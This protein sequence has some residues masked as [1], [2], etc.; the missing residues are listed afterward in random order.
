MFIGLRAL[1]ASVVLFG[2]AAGASAQLTSHRGQNVAP[3]YEGW[4][5]DPDGTRHFVFGYMNRNWEEELDVPV[6]AENFLEPGP[7]DQGQPTRFLPRRNRFVFRV[8]VPPG[9]TDTD[10]VVWT[11]V[12]KGKTEKAF[13]SLRLD[14]FIDNLVK[15]SE[16]G[17]LG[18]GTSDP[19]VRAN[20]GPHLEVEGE[21]QRNVRVG[22]PLELVAIARDDGVPEPRPRQSLSPVFT[23][24]EGKAPGP[25]ENLAGQPPLQVTVDSATGMRLSWYVYRGTGRVTF[26]P[27]QVKVWEDSRTG[28]NSPWAP[29]W[30]APPAPPGG[31]YLVRATFH[32][33]GTFVLRCLTSDGALHVDSDLT[34]TVAP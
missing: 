14:Y 29:R 16:Q 7:A 8:P 27:E 12:T 4:E 19:V 32:Q 9:F 21:R 5:L 17:A 34:I 31:R 20:E 30:V 22:E 1:L 24:S 10:E 18:A 2:G 6:G 33:P 11:L 15:A 28:A 3:A 13:G 23:T 26:D 25:N